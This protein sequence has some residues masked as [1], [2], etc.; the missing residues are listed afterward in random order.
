MKD[1]KIW[2]NFLSEQD[3]LDLYEY[4]TSAALPWFLSLDVINT[5]VNKLE[6]DEK[7]NWQLYHPFYHT[8]CDSSPH[9]E[10][11]DRLLEAVNPT[12]LYRIKANLNPV[13]HEVF[14]H[15]YHI[16]TNSGE[17]ASMITTGIYYLNNNNGYTILEDGTKIENI[18]NRYV[19]FPAN[20]RH[21][22]TT[23]TDA[24][25]RLV[26]NLNYIKVSTQEGNI[27]PQFDLFSRDN[28]ENK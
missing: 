13:A 22:G 17:L 1:L 16:D 11:L 25:F 5:D 12:M 27:N 10:I 28:Q 3:H 14:P 23:C 4:M 6:C 24:P 15:G 19:T 9:G 2:D 26:L 21:T 8:P 20:V 18:A 7:F